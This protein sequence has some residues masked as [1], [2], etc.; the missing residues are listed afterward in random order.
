MDA[1]QVGIIL[2]SPAAERW[3]AS[4]SPRK[5]SCVSYDNLEPC[6]NKAIQNLLIL[7][8]EL[9]QDVCKQSTSSDSTIRLP[10]NSSEDDNLTVRGRGSSVHSQTT[11]EHEKYSD[12]IEGALFLII[13]LEKDTRETTLK[14]DA[15]KE[16][17]CSLR[18]TLDVEAVRRMTLLREAVQEGV[19]VCVCAHVYYSIYVQCIEHEACMRDLLELKWHVSYE[20]RNL[21]RHKHGV[22]TTGTCYNVV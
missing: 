21:N 12:F 2:G 22:T 3:V 13:R 17:V 19:C 9:Q 11:P 18:K 5:R 8:Q 16:K 7:K 10:G 20:G 1:L 14:F 4:L 6:V 15:V